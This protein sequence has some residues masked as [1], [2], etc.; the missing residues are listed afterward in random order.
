MTRK[1][2]MTAI[3]CKGFQAAGIHSGLKA[4]GN[5]DLGLIYSE[6]PATVAGVFTQNR[7]KA[8]P[9]LVNQKR[10]Q[11]GI[12]N[13][14]IVNSGNANCCNGQEGYQSALDMS[15]AAAQG[16]GLA[17]KDVLLASTGV[18]GERFPIEKVESAVPA[19]IEAL[20]PDGFLAC[21]QA[22]MT[23]DTVPKLEHR[24]G[25]NEN[26][27]YNLV[28]MAKGSGMI[29]PNMATMLCFICTDISIPPALLQEMLVSEVDKTLNRICID[30]DTST[31]DTTL[32][33]ANG[34]SHVA[35]KSMDQ[36]AEFQTLLGEVLGSLAKR[37][38]KDGEGVTKCVEI[39]VKGA[40][41]NQDART[42]AD[43]IATSPLVK[44]ALFGEDANWGRLIAAAGRAG[45]P[46]DPDHIDI[47][48]DQVQMAR[49]SLG[50]GPEAEKLATRVLK[51]SEFSIVMDLNMG[52][53]SSS[54]LTC[55]LTIDYIKINADYRS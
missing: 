45:V 12:A 53:G 5:S 11:S 49:S 4:N 34:Q 50:C 17:H 14:I 36:A 40:L 35:M 15:A 27:T 25:R 29:A 41:S 46:L 33:L 2:K 55:D 18:I 31:N 39:L 38:V 44:T 16:L 23:T 10:I 26:R 52:P 24:Q 6:T 19:L 7:I 51:E 9:V 37:L 21:A 13:A 42:I 32:I 20:K 28:G 1:I 43:T 47:Y 3:R 48:F 54:V 8:A 30:G 22:I